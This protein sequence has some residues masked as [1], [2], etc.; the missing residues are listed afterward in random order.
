MKETMGGKETSWEHLGTCLGNL[1]RGFDRYIIGSGTLLGSSVCDL[2]SGTSEYS[3][4]CIVAS[5]N[6]RY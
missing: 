5:S 3:K 4:Y 1:V 6:A 2:C